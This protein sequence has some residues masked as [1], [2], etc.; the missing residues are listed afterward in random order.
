[1]SGAGA[2]HVEA[3]EGRPECVYSKKALGMWEGA[4]RRVWRAK[5]VS[6]F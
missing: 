6:I 3:A 5:K 2:A 4:H 1:M